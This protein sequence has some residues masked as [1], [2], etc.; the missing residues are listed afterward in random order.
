MQ[1]PLLRS[2]TRDAESAYHGVIGY[3]P[4]HASSEDNNVLYSHV[5]E[6]V[7]WFLHLYPE[8]LVC[9]TGDFNPAST[10]ISSAVF[11]RMSG[12]TQIAKVLTLGSG[13]LDWCL[14]NS[15][16]C[17]SNPKQLPRI[18]RS[19]HYCVLVQQVPSTQKKGKRSIIK[20][21]TRDS[22]L[23]GFGRWITSFS[24]DEVFSLDRCEEKFDLFYRIMSDAVNRFLPLKSLPVHSSNKPWISP[25][26]KFLVARRQQALNRFGKNSHAFQMRRN[27]VQRAIT[28]VKKFYYDTKVKGLKY[29]NGGKWW[30]EVK[31][32]A[33]ISDNSG[34]WYRQLVDG[35]VNESVATLSD[36]INDFFVNFNLEFVPLTPDDVAGIAVE[37]IPPELLTTPWE[38]EKALR[39]IKIKK[40]PG[41]D[42]LPNVVLKEFG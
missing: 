22:A 20:R 25:K 9:V 26:I 23:R 41:P 6:T 17:I 12:L 13:T 33:G 14:T 16:K 39:G 27:K 10:N 35:D 3:L 30:K 7:D 18:G 19:D 31:N 29:S 2:Q 40:A 11:K 21:D 42:G 5:Q 36:R 34:Q 38:A 24:W 1:C 15:L 37:S 4:P 8:A 28:S 32:L